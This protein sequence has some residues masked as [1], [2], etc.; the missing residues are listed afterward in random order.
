MPT[1]QVPSTS[2][3][4]WESVTSSSS[5]GILGSGTSVQLP[6]T[7]L[8]ETLKAFPKF[9]A[10]GRSFLIKFN[11]PGEEQEPT[12]YIRGRIISWT[13]Y[14]VSDVSYLHM[15]VFNVLPSGV[16]TNF[17]TFWK[18]P[19]ALFKKGLWLAAYPLPN[20]LEGGVVVRKPHALQVWFEP[21][22]QVEITWGQIGTVRRM[23]QKVPF[24][25][26]ECFHCFG[27]MG[28]CIVLKEGYPLSTCL[29]LGS[30][31]FLHVCCQEVWVIN[32]IDF[33]QL[34]ESL[35]G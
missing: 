27:R 3:N 5:R 10:A 9:K 1:T 31:L 7:I 14:L 4:H 28:A 33:W 21:S 24:Q 17:P 23:C 20:S 26:P 32:C 11:S 22:E 34:S 25:F 12:A 8:D 16:N 15:S 30:D 29:P 18:H 13:N 6:F 19:D 35:H 2:R